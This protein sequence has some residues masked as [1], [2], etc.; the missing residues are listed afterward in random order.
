MK[1]IQILNYHYHYQF[2]ARRILYDCKMHGT[3]FIMAWLEDSA[4]K[5]L[6]S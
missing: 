4:G 6:D 5:R 3:K 2:L 1:K